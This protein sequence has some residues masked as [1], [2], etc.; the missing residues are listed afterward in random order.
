MIRVH[1]RRPH[2][3]EKGGRVVQ[4]GHFADKGKGSFHMR[5]SALF[6]AKHIKFFEIYGVS[7]RTRG[8]ELRQCGHFADKGRGGRQFFTI[9]C[10]RF[11][12]R[13]LML[14][15][16]LRLKPASNLFKGRA[17]CFS[18]QV[19]KNKCFLLNPKKILAQICLAVFEKNGKT[20]L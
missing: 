2:S 16:C 20:H 4:C 17:H 1:K 13:P 9:L 6:G 5:T 7:A 3:R 10:G 8:R 19:V 12:G 11:Y 15:G 14:S 18:M